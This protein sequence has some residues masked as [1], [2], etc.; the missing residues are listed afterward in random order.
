MHS[1]CFPL[2]SLVQ[3]FPLRGQT[4]TPEWADSGLNVAIYTQLP[5]GCG[6]LQGERKHRMMSLIWWKTSGNNSLSVPV[7]FTAGHGWRLSF[8]C[9]SRGPLFVPLQTLIIFPGRC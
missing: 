3:Q 4:F 2:K 8:S 6:H 5:G 7:V 1:P 9:H